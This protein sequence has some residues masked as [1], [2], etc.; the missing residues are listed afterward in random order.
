MFGYYLGN[1][2]RLSGT[3]KKLNPAFVNFQEGYPA[4]V[5]ENGL[6][7][8][9]TIPKNMILIWAT[10]I[11][12]GTIGGGGIFPFNVAQPNGYNASLGSSLGWKASKAGTLENLSVTA[13]VEP[14]ITNATNATPIVIS[15]SRTTGLANGDRVYINGILGNTAANGE[16]IVSDVVAN[17]RF[18]LVDSVGNGNYTSGG[19]WTEEDTLT[20][21]VYKNGAVT[22]MTTSVTFSTVTEAYNIDLVNTASIAYG[23]KIAFKTAVTSNNFIT[24]RITAELHT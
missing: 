3:D 16:W 7:V 13:F 24:M 20:V 5:A 21:T 4:N 11:N 8:D 22:D 18:T 9:I 6:G 23:D 19:V 10:G 14:T 1:I 15:T 17:T 12:F 2:F